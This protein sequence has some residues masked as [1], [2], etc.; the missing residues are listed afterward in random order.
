RPR[1]SSGGYVL[2]WPTIWASRRPERLEPGQETH[3]AVVAHSVMDVPGRRY[4]ARGC[5]QDCSASLA[6]AWQP[7]LVLGVG[8][9]VLSVRRRASSVLVD[10]VFAVCLCDWCHARAGSVHD[11]AW[12]F[13]ERLRA[14]LTDPRGPAARRSARL[15]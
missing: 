14:P 4:G 3:W 10:R 5:G 13:A 8:R 15:R 11:G 7:D 2:A 9:V 12:L 6:G 1:H